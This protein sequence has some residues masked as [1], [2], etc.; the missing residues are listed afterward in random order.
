MKKLFMLI[1]AVI[2]SFTLTACVPQEVICTFPEQETQEVVYDV[3]V[4][5][6]EIDVAQGKLFAKETKAR[7]LLEDYQVE[8]EIYETLLIECAAAPETDVCF[9]IEGSARSVNIFAEIFN[10]YMI[11]NADVWEF[12][13]IPFDIDVVLE[14]IVIETEE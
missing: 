9:M 4:S 8:L 10:E 14:K 6:G 7:L 2:I 5:A 12:V 1:A 13:Q 11:K 3:Q